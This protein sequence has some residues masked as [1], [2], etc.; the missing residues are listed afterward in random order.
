MAKALVLSEDT[1]A[2]PVISRAP[3]QTARARCGT[4]A[5]GSQAAEGS[6][7]A[8]ANPDTRRRRQGDQTRCARRRS[9]H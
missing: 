6:A 4:R 8:A 1:L 3:P 7:S 5:E 9:N 2:A